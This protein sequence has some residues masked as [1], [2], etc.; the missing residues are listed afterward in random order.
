MVKIEQLN[1]LGNSAF[2]GM[3]FQGVGGKPNKIRQQIQASR[4]TFEDRKHRQLEC[5][6]GWPW[7]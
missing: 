4:N 3:G 7:K 1:S 6:H 5:G 2:F